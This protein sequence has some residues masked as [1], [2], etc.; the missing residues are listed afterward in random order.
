MG[1][2]RKFQILIDNPKGVFY[3]GEVVTAQVVLE[4]KEEMKLRGRFHFPHRPVDL[5]ILIIWMSSFLVLGFLVGVFT[6]A[7]V[8]IEAPFSKQS[9][10]HLNWVCN[11]CILF[12]SLIPGAN[13][14]RYDDST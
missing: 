13:S 6:F 10:R 11:V 8:G 5:S 12:S 2:L 9:L 1:K 3:P 14:T 7:V 4:V